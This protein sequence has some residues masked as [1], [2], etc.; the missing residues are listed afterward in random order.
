MLSVYVCQGGRSF[1]IY[2][3]CM[4]WVGKLMAILS[5]ET[6]IYKVRYIFM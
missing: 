5:C 3:L 4:Y 6:G 1:E 2:W